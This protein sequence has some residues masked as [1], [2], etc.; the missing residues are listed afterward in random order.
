[1]DYEALEALLPLAA[2]HNV[3]I[4][5]VHHTRKALGADPIDEISGSFGLTGGVD[6]FLVMRRDGGGKGVSL[7]VD[8]RDIEEPKEYALTRNI[9][10][11]TWT[12]EGEA[13]EVRMSKERSD[14]LLM[15]GRHG[16]QTPKSIAD[17]LGISAG[18]VRKRL[19]GMVQDGQV[20]KGADDKY[21]P[22]DMRPGG[23]GN[24]GNG[25]GNGGNAGKAAWESQN[26]QSVT[27]V[28]DDTLF[29]GNAKSE[30]LTWEQTEEIKRLIAEGMD[31]KQARDEVLRVRR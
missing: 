1:L 3:S 21:R 22:P 29:S 18:T 27:S 10:T 6:G 13:E 25:P 11:G 20:I 8:G 4:L 5:V 16:P 26:T 9:N 7:S 17:L 14:V 2:E 12:I 31:A 23:P 19:I 15:I 28:T 24:D 30:R